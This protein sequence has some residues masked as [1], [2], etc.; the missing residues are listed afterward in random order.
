MTKPKSSSVTFES[1][2]NIY[3]KP[4]TGLANVLKKH[5][6]SSKRIS[7]DTLHI[8]KLVSLLKPHENQDEVFSFLVC[9]ME[10]LKSNNK[11]EAELKY[12]DILAKINT[13]N[14]DSDSL[15]SMSELADKFYNA[16]NKAR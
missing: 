1:L 9:N 3:N 4:G 2:G 6:E 7:N 16:F 12:K 5:E 10:I 11:E 13:S 8:S 14:I 15:N